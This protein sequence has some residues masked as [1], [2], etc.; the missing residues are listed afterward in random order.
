MVINFVAQ[1]EAMFTRREV[2][3]AKRARVKIVHSGY[4]IKNDFMRLDSSHGNIINLDISRADVQRA[5]NIYGSQNVLQGS[6]RIVRPD[7][8]VIRAESMPKHIQDL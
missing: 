3:L 2:D 7:T 4:M 1:N 8:R 6:F 5:I